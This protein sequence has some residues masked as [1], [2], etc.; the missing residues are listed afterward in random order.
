MTIDARSL[1][2]SRLV[3]RTG[4][5]KHANCAVYAGSS[6]AVVAAISASTRASRSF[7]VLLPSVDQLGRGQ[8]K[9]DVFRD[10]DPKKNAV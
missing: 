1:V 9:R 5:R 6:Q 10:R 2:R 3:Q 4:E 8:P 7:S